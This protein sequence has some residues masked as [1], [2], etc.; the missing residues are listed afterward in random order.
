[1]VD[2]DF[3]GDVLIRVGRQVF[4]KRSGELDLAGLYELQNGHRSE[5]LV[6]RT[7]T[8]ASVEFVWNLLLAI[9]Q[10][11]GASKD[12]LAVVGEQHCAGK[13]VRGGVLFELDLQSA[14]AF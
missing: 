2:C 7:N 3:G 4:S 1:M 5:H 9:G 6:H 14:S 10:S 8:E 12:G 13:P 11:V